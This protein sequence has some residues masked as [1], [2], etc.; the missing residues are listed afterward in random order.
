MDRGRVLLDGST[1]GTE[2]GGM[3]VF[4]RVVLFTTLIWGGVNTSLLAQDHLDVESV[5][6]QT[7]DED[8]YA[9]VSAESEEISEPVPS[10]TE[11]DVDVAALLQRLEVLEKS[12]KKRSESDAKKAAD[13]KAKKEAEAAKAEDWIDLSADK[14]TVKLG[15][16]VQLEYVDWANADSNIPPDLAQNYFAYRRLRLSADGTGYGIFDFRLQMTLEPGNTGNLPNGTGISPDVKDAYIT[17]NEIPWLGRVRI[18][19]FFVPFG[20]EQVTNDTNNIFMERSIPTQGIFTADREVGI[21]LYNHNDDQSISW[22]AGAFFDNITDTQKDRIDD[23]QGIRVSG[24]LN[25][26]PY[27]DEPS[28]GRYAT[29]TGIGV[30]YTAL[31]R[32]D[33]IGK[34]V[35]FRARPEIFLGPRLID[36]GLLPATSY[37]VG[38]LEFAQVWGPITVQSEAYLCNVNMISGDS[39]NLSG[40]YV[41][42]SYYLTGENRVYDRFGQHG[43][44]FGR[45]QP[46]SNLF[47]TS[48]G[49][50]L[51]AWE[52]KARISNLN[53]TSVGKGVMNDMTFGLNWLW[54]D[55][56]RVMFD[57]IHPITSSNT[58]FGA[59]QSDLLCMRMDF[60]W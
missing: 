15:G 8:P 35:Q 12:E 22:A 56:T 17:V 23:N 24:R 18:G 34:A 25:W 28:N 40:A 13:E 57:W 29:H 14:W 10:E 37:T 6:E 30:L 58:T 5:F 39:P 42:M 54:S 4:L 9:L 51:G 60:N 7:E 41:H 33:V 3:Q 36:S 20:L 53:L 48:S 59:T 32:Q 52:A 50:S 2:A 31:R 43:A 49:H 45:Y 21:A 1:Q 27:Y 46:Y 26:V 47:F 38:N 19:N 55:R 16:H 11:E 44:Q